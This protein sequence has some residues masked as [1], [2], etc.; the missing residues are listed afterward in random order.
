M[1][2]AQETANKIFKQVDDDGSGEIQFSEFC[3]ATLD[4]NKILEK[5]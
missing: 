5:Q 3:T 2:N 4:Q 1:A